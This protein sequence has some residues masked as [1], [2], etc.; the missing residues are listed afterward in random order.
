MWTTAWTRQINTT[1]VPWKFMSEYLKWVCRKQIFSSIHIIKTN[2]TLFAGTAHKR[3][4][5]VTPRYTMCA[6]RMS[7]LTQINYWFE[8]KPSCDWFACNTVPHFTCY[9]FYYQKEQQVSQ[10]LEHHAS[11]IHRHFYCASG[12]WNI[13]IFLNEFSGIW[14]KRNLKSSFTCN[15]S[16][17]LFLCL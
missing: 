13:C 6:T 11:K 3:M 1:T 16:H 12:D 17:A 14:M 10:M 7:C 9:I 2:G 5:H 8:V 4:P 15:I